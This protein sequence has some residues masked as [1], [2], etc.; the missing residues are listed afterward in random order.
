MS[1]AWPPPPDLASIQELVREA[2][3]EGL[4]TEGAPGDEYEPEGEKIFE[5]IAH[6]ETAE[7]TSS[8]ILPLLER[9]WLD[10][11][12][13]ELALRR[14]ALMSLAGQIERFFGPEAVPQTR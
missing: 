10:S 11:F 2:D 4:I 14:P 8:R 9:I 12:E 6:L 3:V 7:I 13:A 1:G 5:A